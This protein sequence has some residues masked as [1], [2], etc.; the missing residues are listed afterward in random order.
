MIKGFAIVAMRRGQPRLR[1]FRAC[2][3]DACAAMRMTVDSDPLRIEPATV[4]FAS[5]GNVRLWNF[6]QPH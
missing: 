1:G 4:T 2:Q 3:T 6:I 5:N